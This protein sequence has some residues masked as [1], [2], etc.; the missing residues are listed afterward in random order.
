[1]NELK[2]T[3]PAFAPG[4]WIPARHCGYD[5]DI[6]PELRVEG[7]EGAVTLAVTLDDMGHPIF[8][9]YNHWVA[10]NLPAVSVIPEGIPTGALVEAPIHIEQGM[11]YGK[12]RYRGP[13]PPFNW[14][15]DYRF[16]VYALDC[17]LSLGADADKPALLA[18]MDGHILAAGELFGKYQR[19]HK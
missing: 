13:K 12:H 9:G 6:S 18:A 4:D 19:R 16:T 7:A 10:W 14:L 15:H 8:P 3:S 5:K 11:A 2:I 1:M 17:S